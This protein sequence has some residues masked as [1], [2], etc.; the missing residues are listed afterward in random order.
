M[1]SP[2]GERPPV[3]LQMVA[4]LVVVLIYAAVNIPL[5]IMS[6]LL[7]ARLSAA[8][9]LERDGTD[10][11]L[12]RG[13]SLL[14]AL[15]FAVLFWRFLLR[16]AEG[17]VLSALMRIRR[18]PRPAGP[19]SGPA[20]PGPAAPRRTVLVP[21]TDPALV[22]RV[23]ELQ[24]RQRTLRR[25]EFPFGGVVFAIDLLFGYQNWRGDE[26]DST[27]AAVYVASAAVLFTLA[28]LDIR[29]NL[30]LRRA[31][32]AEL[33]GI[34]PAVGITPRVLRRKELMERWRNVILV[35]WLLSLP[36]VLLGMLVIEPAI[37][38][39]IGTNR[40]VSAIVIWAPMVVLCT[41][42]YPAA[43]LHWRLM[44]LHQRLERELAGTSM[45]AVSDNRPDPQA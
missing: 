35:V 30:K 32:H 21:A 2:N 41:G 43:F 44:R 29:L 19:A 14:V 42:F 27:A 23:R 20:A 40:L 28:F 34:A 45:V 26:L 18:R 22:H 5:L 4:R 13:G 37:K 6:I 25:I 33:A 8:W 31:E 16:R 38:S 7:G 3:G 39:A 15:V 1:D 9:G 11:Y 12:V 24:R 10:A 36:L 17:P